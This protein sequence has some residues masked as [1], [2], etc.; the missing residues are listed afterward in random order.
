MQRGVKL[1]PD[2][3]LINVAMTQGDIQTGQ[4]I[5]SRGAGP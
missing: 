2:I 5:T 4:G 3:Q 1:E